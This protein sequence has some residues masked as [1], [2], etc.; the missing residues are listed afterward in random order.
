MA[1]KASPTRNGFVRLSAMATLCKG[2]T[3]DQ[4]ASIYM[5]TRR[6]LQNWIRRFNESGI[7]G[8]IDKPRSGRPRK[9]PLDKTQELI[10]V[11]ENPQMAKETHWTA[12]K[13][14]GYLQENLDE[15]LGYRTVVRWLHEQ[16]FRLKVPQPWPDRQNEELR[17]AFIDRLKHWLEDEEIDL[18]YLDETGIEGDPRPRRRWAMKGSKPRVTKNGGHV[19]MNVTGMICP[20]TG[21]F[22]ALE[23]THSD[24]AI[25]QVFLDEANRDL[26]LKRPRNLL[27]MDNASWHKRKSTIWGDFEPIY[28]PP[29]SPD[30]NPIER[31]W[32]VLK[33]E[34]FSDFIA[35]SRD[36]LCQRLDQALQWVIQRKDQN[37][38]TCA[39]QK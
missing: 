17:T 22:F 38:I 9:I 8:L 28:L 30:L 25:F 6:T 3:H 2:F 7:D 21:E 1:A 18:W 29:Y 23:F 36:E 13:F 33:A 4:V 19:R 34:W 37:Q 20:R 16:D 10:K 31:L 39:N 26:V 14:H 11:I 27:I 15:E 12:R 35:K 5:V 32:L 24:S